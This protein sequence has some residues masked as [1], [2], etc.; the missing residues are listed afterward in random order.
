MRNLGD[1]CGGSRKV[2]DVPQLFLKDT[3]VSRIY[4]F[5][6]LENLD[7][8]V[9]Y[10]FWSISDIS[11]IIVLLVDGKKKRSLCIVRWLSHSDIALPTHTAQFVPM[12]VGLRELFLF[13]STT[14]RWPCGL[15]SVFS[16]SKLRSPWTVQEQTDDADLNSTSQVTLPNGTVYYYAREYTPT[17]EYDTQGSNIHYL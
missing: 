2:N 11:M 1:Q 7:T 3:D 6:Y 13:R 9:T 15:W 10:P 12:I 16:L 4:Q 8:Y 17:T 14:K 5:L